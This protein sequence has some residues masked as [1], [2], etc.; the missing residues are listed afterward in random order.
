MLTTRTLLALT[1][2]AFGTAAAQTSQPSLRASGFG[3]GLSS[4][5]LA[6]QP[7]TRGAKGDQQRHY[8]FAAAQKEMPYR[9]YVPQSYD[10]K[11][12]T[13]L[14][15]ALHGY[16]GNHNYFFALVDNLQ[17]LCDQYGFIFV[18]PMGYSTGS[19]YGAPLEIPN[20]LP[21]PTGP[22][23]K[24]R[25][26]P[27]IPSKPPAEELRERQLGEADVFNVLELVRKEYNVDPKRT[28]LMGHSMGG[29]GTWFLGQKHAKHWAALAPMS[30]T[31][32]PS[33]YEL[34]K[35][36]KIPVLLSAGSTEMSTVAESKEIVER[37]TKAGMT[38]AFVEIEG[39][40][41]IS[42]IAPTMPKI[43]E[44]FAKHKKK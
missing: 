36:A 44:F 23:G 17:Q 37:M 11:K 31:M 15:V 38:A 12:K 25:S 7:Q 27:T 10:K 43:F 40:T 2:L 28:Y 14:I 34:E 42:M 20:A 26:V 3:A 5:E 13:P 8:Y 33:D 30:G 29:Y 22:D 4:E 19:W 35:L 32:R 39:G 21:R 16:S 1:L 41:H 6:K 24:P 9:L 18:A